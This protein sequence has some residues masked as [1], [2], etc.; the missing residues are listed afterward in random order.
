MDT[1]NLVSQ[2]WRHR[3]DVDRAGLV[4]SA[5]PTY[6]GQVYNGGSIPTA[7]GRVYLTRP[8]SV[9]VNDVENSTPT[10]TPDTSLSVPVLVLG[11]VATAGTNLLAENVDGRWVAEV[12]AASGCSSGTLVFTVT[13]CSGAALSGA[14]VSVTGPGGFSASGTTNGSGQVTFPIAGYPAGS[15]P[16]TVS[17][18]PNFVS[19]SG[20]KTVSCGVA[21]AVSVS[22]S[23]TSGYT[24]LSGCCG[25]IPIKNNLFLTTPFGTTVAFNFN[26]LGGSVWEALVVENL[27]CRKGV[28]C[29]TASTEACTFYW[30]MGSG[31]T[32][33]GFS[34]RGVRGG[35]GAFDITTS[36]P[37]MVCDSNLSCVNT[38]ANIQPK[39]STTPVRTCAPFSVTYSA[40]LVYFPFT[41]VRAN[42]GTVTVTE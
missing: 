30:A 27:P 10:F 12:L 3:D 42:Y 15:Y 16:W 26:A 36:P 38:D 1:R 8:V 40:E 28:G 32:P 11:G 21:N 22:L 34:V 4:P 33:L 31:C 5:P 13:G 37:T 39:V 24:C 20:T 29:G 19:A 41:G 7:A 17:Y 2:L 6:L 25:N 23:A 35:N 18:A 14:T 9:A